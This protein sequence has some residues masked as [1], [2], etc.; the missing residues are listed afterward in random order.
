MSFV[1]DASVVHA[2]LFNE[3]SAVG[4]FAKGRLDGEPAVAPRLWWFE[5]RNGLVMAE[6]RQRLTKEDTD[7]ALRQLSGLT[8]AFDDAPDEA[9]VVSLAREHRLTVYDAAYLELAMRRNLPLATL[10]AALAAA[11]RVEGVR[12]IGA[13]PE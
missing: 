8:I 6:R 2:W 1:L 9:A 11:A 4:E 7:A 10:D 12:L 5:V 3:R 13:A